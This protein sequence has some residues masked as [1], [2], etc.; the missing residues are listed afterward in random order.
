MGPIKVWDADRL[1]EVA[2][3]PGHAPEAKAICWSPDGRRL[4]SGGLDHRV[5][6]WDLATGRETATLS[7]HTDWVMGVSWTSDGHRLA[8][9]SYDGTVKVWDPDKGQETATLRGHQDRVNAASWTPDCQRLASASWDK[10]IRIWDATRGYTAERSPALLPIL[11]QRLAVQPQKPE[12]LRLRA[13]IHAR[14]GR[15]D[16]AAADWTRAAHL[17]EA[18][19]PRPFP[20]GWWV[21]GPTATTTPPSPETDVEPDPFQSEWNVVPGASSATRLHWRAVTVSPSG[22][23]DLGAMFPDARSGSARALLRVYSPREQPVTAQLGS[24]SSYRCWMNGQPV[25]ETS[26]ERPR[27]GDDEKVVLTLRAGW[28]TLL[29]HVTIGTEHDWLSVEFE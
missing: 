18:G 24:S 7:G 28:N 14:L 21:L 15:W 1:R 12:D 25:R 29:F 5:R 23:L 16:D 19:A 4:A 13:E 3:F 8:S 10:T 6:V 17:R 9:A 22:S 27:D 20:A 26:S 11:A 2:T